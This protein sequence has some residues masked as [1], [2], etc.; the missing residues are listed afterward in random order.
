MMAILPYAALALVVVALVSFR[1][2]EQG[3]EPPADGDTIR[4]PCEARTLLLMERL[5]DSSDYRWLRDEIGRP[6]L[7]SR[8]ARDRKRMAIRCL[9][10]LRTW[11][12]R[13]FY[14]SSEGGTMAPGTGQVLWLT[15]QSRLLL[16][17][18]LLVVRLV[19]PYHQLI[20]RFK[21]R[22]FIDEGA[23]KQT[24]LAKE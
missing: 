2:L 16:E 10:V 24:T 3:S 23:W 7:A 14:D 22:D 12:D 11:F 5:F 13:A 1:R 15:L 8:V 18:A 19:G 6:D 20:P 9:K 21:L 17:Y 4:D